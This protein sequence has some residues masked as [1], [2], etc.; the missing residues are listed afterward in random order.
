MAK[1]RSSKTRTVTL[2][3]NQILAAEE[4]R[5]CGSHNEP[6]SRACPMGERHAQVQ[7]LGADGI[8]LPPT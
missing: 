3:E 8:P 5:W 1:Q 7:Q 2:I 6:H 4:C